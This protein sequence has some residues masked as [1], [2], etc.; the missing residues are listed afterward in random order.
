MLLILTM[1][2]GSILQG[3]RKLTVTEF[4]AKIARG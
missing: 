1:H 4:A 2:S 3:K